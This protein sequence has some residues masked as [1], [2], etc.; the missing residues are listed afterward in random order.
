MYHVTFMHKLKRNYK[1]SLDK[2]NFIICT[3]LKECVAVS[4]NIGS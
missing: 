3:M 4:I 2:K 1:S